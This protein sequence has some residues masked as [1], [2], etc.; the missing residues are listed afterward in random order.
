M[1]LVSKNLG[2]MPGDF[3]LGVIMFLFCLLVVVLVH[4]TWRW[5]AVTWLSVGALTALT[6]YWT[7]PRRHQAALLDLC[8]LTGGGFISV[9]AFVSV[10]KREKRAG[11]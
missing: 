9:A 7:G 8:A 1:R 6:A 3:L 2:D 10:W 5:V 11:C 4:N